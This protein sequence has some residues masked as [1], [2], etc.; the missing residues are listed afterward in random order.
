VPV[1]LVGGPVRDAVLDVPVQDLD[2]VLV[3]N[4]PVLATEIANKLGGEV[5]VHSRFG[6]ATVE[7]AG[8]YVDIVTARKETY[9]FPASLPETSPSDLNDDLARRDFSI[10]A[11]ALP[12]SGESPQV[13][14][15][16][17]G[18]QHLAD[19]SIAVLHNESFIDDPTRMLR[20]VRYAQRLGFQISAITKFALERSIEEGHVTTVSGDRWRQELQKIFSEKQS[21]EMLLKAIDLGILG[22]IHPALIKRNG[23]NQLVGK[24]GLTPVDYLSAFA[25]DLTAAD[26]ESVSTRLNLASDWARILHDTIALQGWLSFL[27]VSTAKT[28]EICGELDGLNPEAIDALARFI[29]D[30]EVSTMLSQYLNEWRHKKPSLTGD[31]LLTMGVPQ[32]IMVG[33]VLRELHAAVLD[34]LVK[35]ETEE[36]ILVEQIL[37]RRS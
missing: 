23:L 5:T 13:I 25:F 29:G 18:L 9:P 7:V 34:G 19:R 3:G 35:G 8:D 26:G 15:P 1:Y 2:F 24:P 30:L 6:T 4:A 12:L 31:I 33:D 28:S 11:M 22:A 37:S 10:N 14:D 36:R 21:P 32:G 16:H 17:G 27:S 20:A